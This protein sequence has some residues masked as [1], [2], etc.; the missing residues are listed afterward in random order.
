MSRISTAPVHKPYIIASEIKG[1][2]HVHDTFGGKW[3]ATLHTLRAG[4]SWPKPSRFTV[5]ESTSIWFIAVATHPRNPQARKGT[6][7]GRGGLYELKDTDLVFLTERH[8]LLAT[9]TSRDSE[10][11]RL[12]FDSRT[13]AAA[14]FHANA[15]HINKLFHPALGHARYDRVVM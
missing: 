7:L 1:V 8:D 11:H 5:P 15:R 12:R 10:D 13:D 2:S 6:L 4:E 14:F 3:Q 9:S